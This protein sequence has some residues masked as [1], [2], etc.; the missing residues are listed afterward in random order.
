VNS[1]PIRSHEFAGTFA[2]LANRPLRVWRVPAAATRLVVGPVSADGFQADAVFS[3]I[4]LRAIG[5]RFR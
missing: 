4:R 5:F 1:H 3:N 2:R